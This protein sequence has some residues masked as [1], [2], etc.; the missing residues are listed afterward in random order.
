MHKELEKSVYK[1]SK[2]CGSDK[3]TILTNHIKISGTLCNC[4]EREDIEGIISLTDVSVWLLDDLC[5]C[6]DDNC[7]CTTAKIYHAEWL[8]INAKKIVAFSIIK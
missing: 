8:N 5:K 4:E 6:G 1:V 3:I 2:K 7:K